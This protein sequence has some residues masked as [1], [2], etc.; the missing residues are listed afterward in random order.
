MRQRRLGN[1]QVSALGLGCMGMSEFYGSGDEAESIATIHRA[2]ELGV[3]FLDTADMYGVG[4]NE[5]LIGRAIADRRDQVFLATKFGNMRGPNGERG[6]VNGRPDYVPVACEASLKRLGIDHIDIYYQ[7]RIDP[8]VPI[9]ET[10][11]AMARLVEAGKVRYLGLCEAGAD[12]IRRAHAVHPLVAL[13]TEYS[14]WTRDLEA[15]IISLLRQLGI[16]L[17]PYSP[18]GRG[19]LTGAFRRRDDLIPTD[20]RHAHPRFQEGHFERN[21]A[22][23]DAIK[24]I[25]EA[26]GCTLAQVALAWVLSRGP[27]VVP[28]PGTKRRSYLEQNVGA[29]G[30]TLGEADLR[31]LEAA[32]APGVASG[33]RYPEK[34][35]KG[36]GI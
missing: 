36:L 21:L 3:T 18:L 34:Q 17:V 14:L 12:T 1:L 13:Q 4:H 27:D 31:D 6:I 25:A 28:I 16:A 19:F 24:G 22:L 11:G 5:E 30:V 35:L 7:H 10:V 15:E 23:L 9:E 32:F 2:I 26:K 8:K 33:P 20:R 29:L